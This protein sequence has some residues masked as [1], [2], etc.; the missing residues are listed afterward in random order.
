M[1]AQNASS[2]EDLE[3]YRTALE[4]RCIARRIEQALPARKREVK[5]KLLASCA[6]LLREIAHGESAWDSI[7]QCSRILGRLQMVE[8][9]GKADVT[10]GIEVL[11]RIVF[12]LHGEEKNGVEEKVEG[13]EGEEKNGL[14][15]KGKAGEE[16][17]KNGT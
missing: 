9:G 16:E 12:L 3:V 2:Y 8:L 5:E 11:E 7:A 6:N 14:K 13:G 17:E 4:F 15:E 10:A 1:S